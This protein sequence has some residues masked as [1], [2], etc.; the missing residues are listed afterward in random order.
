MKA[1]VCDICGDIINDFYVARVREFGFTISN[2]DIY[3]VPEPYKT[4][5]K[6]HLCNYCFEGFKEIAKEKARKRKGGAE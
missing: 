1:Y 5:V 6:I 4:K 3:Q 2:T